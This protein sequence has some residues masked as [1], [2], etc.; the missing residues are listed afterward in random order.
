MI[1]SICNKH[2]SLI[3]KIGKQRKQSLIVSATELNF[4]NVLRAAF[5]HV[6][7]ESAMKTIKLSIFFLCFWDQQA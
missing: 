2:S 4:I 7:P 1:F 3:A 5:T 6:D